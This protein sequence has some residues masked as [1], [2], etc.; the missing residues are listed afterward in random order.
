MGAASGSVTIR[1]RSPSRV[2]SKLVLPPIRNGPLYTLQLQSDIV[3]TFL[4]G[5]D[6]RPAP[7]SDGAIPAELVSIGGMDGKF[8]RR[9]YITVQA[10]GQSL[11]LFGNKKQLGEHL[12]AIGCAQLAGRIAK[13]L[14]INTSC[15]ILTKPSQNGKYTDVA[16]VLPARRRG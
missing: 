10:N 3:E 8:G 9:L 14:S 2:M 4:N 15:R 12:T 5:K 6:T 1:K 13:G 7:D 11:R 16:Q